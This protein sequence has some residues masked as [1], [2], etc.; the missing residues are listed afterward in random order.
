LANTEVILII[1]GETFSA[2][3]KES[4]GIHV[5]EGS[6]CCSSFS[7][8]CDDSELHLFVFKHA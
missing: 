3:L 7:W 2:N 1:E 6:I 5:C 4:Q 8:L